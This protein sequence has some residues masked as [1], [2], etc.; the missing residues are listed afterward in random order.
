MPIWCLRVQGTVYLSQY[1]VALNQ[2]NRLK[3]L[4]PWPSRYDFRITQTLSSPF[5][6]DI[7][8]LQI[9]AHQVGKVEF[10][11]IDTPFL[12]KQWTRVVDEKSLIEM[13]DIFIDQFHWKLDQ[14]VRASLEKGSS[15]SLSSC[16]PYSICQSENGQ[17]Q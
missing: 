14:I 7:P 1:L 5:D 4:Q 11:F 15:G 12:K 17:Y 9:K 16:S 3:T 10:R 6:G 13:F 8:Y 2:C